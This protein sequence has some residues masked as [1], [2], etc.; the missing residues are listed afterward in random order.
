M[1]HRDGMDEGKEELSFVP[2]AVSDSAGWREPPIH[3]TGYAGRKV[4]HRADTVGRRR[5]AAHDTLL[6]KQLHYEA[7]RMKGTS[8]ERQATERSSSLMRPR[9]KL[10]AGMGKTGVRKTRCGRAARPKKRCFRKACLRTA[11]NLVKSLIEE[12]PCKE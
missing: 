3:V 6:L 1:Y 4:S 9:G 5:R 12:S 8:D 7:R 11:L 10:L 2:S